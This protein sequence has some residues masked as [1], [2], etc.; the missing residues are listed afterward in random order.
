VTKTGVHIIFLAKA[1]DPR[2]ERWRARVFVLTWIAYLGFYLTRYSFSAAKGSLDLPDMDETTMG[3][4][5][6][7]YLVSY[8]VG[9]FIWGGLSDKLGPRRI[10]LGGLL[11]SIICAVAMGASGYLTAFL[12]INFFQGLSQSCG[13]APIAKILSCW[14]SRHERGQVLGWWST[15][16]A[17]GSVVAF[18][19]AG[20][21][22]VWFG[23]WSYAFYVPAACLFVIFL[24]LYF[25][26][27]D[28]P[29]DVGLPSIDVY[30]SEME[31]ENDETDDA[32]DDKGTANADVDV[33][34]NESSSWL[35]LIRQ[36]MIGL[37]A[38]TYFLLKPTRYAILLWGPYYVTL[39][40]Q[41]GVLFSATITAMFALAGVFA[42]VVAGTVSD[43]LFNARRMPFT[44]IC[45]ITLS[46][47]LFMFDGVVNQAVKVTN[48]NQLATLST[49]LDEIAGDK[50]DTAL[51]QISHELA[52]LSAQSSLSDPETVTKLQYI[53]EQLKVTE[54]SDFDQQAAM[55]SFMIQ[56]RKIA[57]SEQLALLRTA[58]AYKKNIKS[59]N[60]R[61]EKFGLHIDDPLLVNMSL[62]TKTKRIEI[63]ATV[64]RLAL[65][66]KRLEI[67]S[68]EKPE[69]GDELGVMHDEVRRMKVDISDYL[70]DR[71]DDMSFIYQTQA[72]DL[73]KELSQRS[74]SAALLAQFDEL[75]DSASLLNDSNPGLDQAINNIKTSANELADAELAS[76][77][78]TWVS[79]L[80]ADRSYQPL[81]PA[82]VMT[83]AHWIMV[84]W[85]VLIGF[86]LQAPDSLIA[87][88]AAIDFGH[89]KG[90]SSTSGFINGCGSVSAIFGGAGVGYIAQHYSWS[91]LLTGFGFMALLAALLLIPKW[92]AI[93]SKESAQ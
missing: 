29:Q 76:R 1:K 12:I 2:Y 93:P 67:L 68:L 21:A 82:E 89:H 54:L 66:Q 41:T 37:L 4:I 15:C 30:H 31:A 84:L 87:V 77:I 19:L 20:G 80:Q 60:T 79:M 8:A 33:D 64:S 46:I 24:I 39:K 69:F 28:R 11:G 70:E 65:I 6:S 75:T 34:H 72:T 10:L 57:R 3:L 14:Y 71:G 61:V 7:V 78:Q 38:T 32:A 83:N 42:S 88:S 59:I 22:I 25:F 27:A 18:A 23:H 85:L 81:R 91:I 49:Q 13:W 47:A 26:H 36:P 90:A 43:R 62:L 40:L 48:K 58:D 86:F 73:A 51:P 50:A 92:N 17:A 52:R 44:V 45:L 9:Q 56:L 55:R 16:Y 35:D 53:V 74:D 5:D 63:S